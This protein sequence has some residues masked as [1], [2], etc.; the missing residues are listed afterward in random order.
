ML[1]KRLH[2][3]T[4]LACQALD[5]QSQLRKRP[6]LALKRA[7]RGRGIFMAD[8]LASRALDLLI[9]PASLR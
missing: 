8:F 9:S 6:N 4:I 1:T 7:I 5:D 3:A 2:G